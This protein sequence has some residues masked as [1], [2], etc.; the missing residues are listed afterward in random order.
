MFRF[1]LFFGFNKSTKFDTQSAFYTKSAVCS[2]HFYILTDLR[3]RLANG[4]KYAKAG[5]FV[6]P[7]ELPGA[8]HTV[9]ILS[10]SEMFCKY[11]L[12]HFRLQTMLIDIQGTAIPRLRGVVQLDHFNSLS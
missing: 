8:R 10:S 2:L 4:L 3:V 6:I 5:V 1:K 9:S 12:G 11:L 7:V